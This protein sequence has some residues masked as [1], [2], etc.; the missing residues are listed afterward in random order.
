MYH[1][2]AWPSVD[3][4]KLAPLRTH[5]RMEDQF[6]SA[7]A[8]RERGSQ[9]VRQRSIEAQRMGLAGQML[10]T[11]ALCDTCSAACAL[12]VIGSRDCRPAY[13]ALCRVKVGGCAVGSEKSCP[14]KKWTE[15]SPLVPP[16]PRMRMGLCPCCPAR[17]FLP[18][19]RPSLAC[20]RSGLQVAALMLLIGVADGALPVQVLDAALG[21]PPPGGGLWVL[22]VAGSSG[23]ANYRH[24]ADVCHACQA[25]HGRGVPK[26]QIIVMIFDDVAK[27]FFN[28]RKGL[29]MPM[30]PAALM[31]TQV[32][33]DYT[34][35][36]IT[37]K[38]F[39]AAQW[40]PRGHARGARVGA[41][42]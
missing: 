18:I 20:L 42:Y 36:S 27:S 6:D 3:R 39:L 14:K 19:M 10:S 15:Q 30:S 8:A 32:P 16:L 29:T 7:H 33:K 5:L 13:T 23:Y 41:C 22:L 21:P 40:R 9:C 12:R 11:G 28:T 38:N 34:K 4:T 17:A 35:R 37:P 2:H 1:L 24:R 26:E 25:V 31:Y